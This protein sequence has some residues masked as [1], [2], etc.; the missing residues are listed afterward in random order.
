M[1]QFVIV[2]NRV[3]IPDKNAK[4]RAGGL[5]VAV[6]A[7]FKNRSGIWFGWSGKVTTHTKIA[8]QKVER[9]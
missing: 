9:S 6:N 4:Q 5:E 7:A 2:S 1:A 3:A 8:T